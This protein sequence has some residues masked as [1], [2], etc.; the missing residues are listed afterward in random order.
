MK[1][2]KLFFFLLLLLQLLTGLFSDGS[3]LV[4]ILKRTAHFNLQGGGNTAAVAPG[5]AQQMKLQ[6]PKKTRLF[7]DQ[8]MR[9]R[10][11]CVSKYAN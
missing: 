2:L 10:D 7:L 11:N 1:H 4:K 8:T 3:L 6:V 9:E 5:A